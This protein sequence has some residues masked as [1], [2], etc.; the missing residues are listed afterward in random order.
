[1]IAKPVELDSHFLRLPALGMVAAGVLLPLLG[2]PGTACPL[3]TLTG[4]PCPLCG[5]S[6]SVED[7]LRGH[8][9]TAAR[10]NP[11]G[12]VALA[13]AGFVVVARRRYVWRIPLAAVFAVLGAAW[14]VE[15][16]RFKVV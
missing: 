4:I 2:H 10:T 13:I 7:A 16:L 14:V 9:W 5:A 15:L 12:V 6:T 8:L 11:L 3:R 1:M